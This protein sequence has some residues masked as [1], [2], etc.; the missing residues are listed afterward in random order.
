MI[1]RLEAFRI[2]STAQLNSF[3]PHEILRKRNDHYDIHFKKQSMI[4]SIKFSDKLA[5]DLVLMQTYLWFSIDERINQHVHWSGDGQRSSQRLTMAHLAWFQK[6]SGRLVSILHKTRER[7]PS[8][9]YIICHNEERYALEIEPVALQKYGKG[10]RISS[11]ANL[12]SKRT[13]EN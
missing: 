9:R 13:S 10:F 5:F 11:E 3:N 2:I 8:K 6:E 1:P 4:P 7:G 12:S